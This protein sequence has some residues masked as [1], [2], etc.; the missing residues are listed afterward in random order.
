MWAPINTSGQPAEAVAL[1][2]RL[3]MGQAIP[4]QHPGVVLR[5]Q[6]NQLRALLAVAMVA[7]VGL[8]VAVVILATDTDQVASTSSAKPI[9]SI[10]YGDSKYVNPSTGYPTAITPRPEAG[11]RPD[12]GPEEGISGAPPPRQPS[13]AAGTRP[14]GGPEEGISGATTARLPSVAAGTRPDGGPEEGTAGVTSSQPR[15]TEHRAFP[16]LSDRASSPHSEASES[17]SGAKDYSMNGA[18]GDVAPEPEVK[19]GSRPDGGPEEGMHLV[20]PGS[21]N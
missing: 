3:S 5:S 15:V 13:V 1:D 16:G 6:F 10:N 14:D 8:T 4:R 17:Q 9:E 21:G 12:G 7:V 18:T 19:F 20:R 2:R 11:T